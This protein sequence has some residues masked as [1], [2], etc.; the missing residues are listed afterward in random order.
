M[1]EIN[2]SKVFSRLSLCA[3]IIVC[4]GC[5]ISP[6]PEGIQK[7][8]AL[9]YP[10]VEKFSQEMIT[11][12]IIR[13]VGSKGTGYVP[14]DNTADRRAFENDFPLASFPNDL[15]KVFDRSYL[16]KVGQVIAWS[17]DL[18]RRTSGVLRHEGT[19]VS[20]T[21]RF[22]YSSTRAINSD[23]VGAAAIS[24]VANASGFQV[25]PSM[26]PALGGLG[27]GLVGG[28]ISGL[29]TSFAVESTINGFIKSQD[30]GERMGHASGVIA[31]QAHIP[32]MQAISE[33]FFGQPSPE[34]VDSR[35]VRYVFARVGEKN[36]DYSTRV[37]F[38]S[39]I[40]A[41]RGKIYE[42]KYPATKGWE[43][44]VTNINYVDI[45]ASELDKYKFI[46]GLKEQ[47]LS[48]N[49]NL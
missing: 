23:A 40:A 35:V 2:I 5:A 37:F 6:I 11:E 9:F 4:T 20:V 8:D 32:H 33:F 31:H 24:M 41:Y 15:S 39:T 30:F 14:P 22:N 7:A 13:I 12:D 46:K 29:I 19:P 3:L 28:I 25:V 16:D 34:I 43:F 21:G 18:D 27:V 49:L 26:S 42:E 17:I 1:S 44:V 47:I 38:A 48:K 36:L 10:L 45:R